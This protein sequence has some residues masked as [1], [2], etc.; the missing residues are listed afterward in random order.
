MENISIRSG[1]STLSQKFWTPYEP[2]RKLIESVIPNNALVVEVGPGS[3]P[4]SRATEFIDWQLW[5]NLV[6]KR[7]HCLDLNKDSLPYADKSVDFIYCRHTLEDIYNPFWLC[8]E[9]QRVAKAGYIETP[10]PLSEVCRGIDGGSPPWRGYVHHR[11]LVWEDEGTL[12]FLPKYPLIDYLDFGQEEAEI[13]DLLNTSPMYWN[14]HFLWDQSISF[15]QLEHDQSFK[16]NTDY[17]EVIR[18]AIAA[19]VTTNFEFSTRYNV[20]I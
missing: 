16:I 3:M 6:D 5:P 10:S 2:V 12:N 4:F 9:M 8:R 19:S 14:T 17:C 7:I 18:N 1:Q 20:P 13:I 15:R 11:Y